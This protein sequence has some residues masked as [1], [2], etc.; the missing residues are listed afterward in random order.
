M[1]PR[2]QYGSIAFTARPLLALRAWFMAALSAVWLMA[3]IRPAA[4]DLPSIR[5]DRLRPLGAA[6]GTEVDVE[7]Q[8][9]DI[10]GAKA[11]LFDHPGLIAA[12]VPEKERLFKLKIAADVPP[13]TY[14]VY[15]IGRFGVS[16]PRLFAVSHGL[17]DATDNG[18]NRTFETAQPVEVNTAVNGTVDGNAADHYRFK[19]AQGQR[20][21]IDCQAQRLDVELDG[22]M[23]LYAASGAL[24]AS[25]GDYYGTDP[26]L[27]VVAPADGEYVVALHDLSYRGGYPYR[28]VITDR[29]QIE[30]VFP[31]VVK[32]G[33]PA[34]LTALGRN[35]APLGG[36]PSGRSEGDLPL[37]QLTVP[38]AAPPADLLELGRYVFEHH[39][40]H[41]SSLP[42]AA[43]CTVT[44]LQVRPTGAQGVWDAQ[45]VLVTEDAVVLEAEPNNALEGPQAISLPAVV[46]GRFD[47]PRDADWYQFQT[48]AEGA[49]SI[50]VYCERIAGRAD[51]YVVVVD[52]QGNRIAEFDDFGH[53]VNAFDG[54][55]RDPSQQVSLGKDR[56]YRVL[57]QDRYRRGGPR[58]QYV[59]EVR[60]ARPDFYAAVIHSSN[61]NPGGT[62]IFKGTPAYL[63]VVIHQKGGYNGP[64]TISAE[65]LPPGVHFQ[66]AATPNN[67]RGTF[68]LWADADAADWTGFVRLVA[69]GERDGQPFRREVRPYSRVW[70]NSG[71]SRPQRKLALA[72]RETGP[73]E[74]V[75]EPESV[76]VEAGKTAELKLKLVR[77]WP[78]FIGAVTVQPL[79]FPGQFQLGNFEIPAGQTEAVLRINVQPGTRP[80]RYTLTLLGQAQVPF[81]KDSRAQSKPNTLVSLPSRP[82]TLTVLPSSR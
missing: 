57:V 30:N 15:L 55:L 31:P 47:Q 66:P 33:E 81:S 45:P 80:D 65:D 22:H 49:Y 67:S 79:G 37:D 40:T 19:A 41:H 4:A 69:T 53:R 29:P 11:L 50:D 62:T 76:D 5:F 18:Q 73:F 63:D 23:T 34:R 74:L 27:D 20:I 16:N 60:K 10:E 46:A 78:E 25:N 77:R 72:V 14:D 75:I 36:T 9:A 82:V 48:D 43:T 24:V 39:P 13:G 54:H 28:L 52:D 42:T 51:P 12:P 21:V 38:L 68:V 59:L 64:V 1:S 6:A 35:L 8:G 70:N 17:T 3:A 56:R 58:Y 44:G 71:T 61:P 7:I 32:A 2:R 26:F